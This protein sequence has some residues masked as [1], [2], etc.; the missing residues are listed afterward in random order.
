MEEILNA[1]RFEIEMLLFGI[2][3]NPHTHIGTHHLS[4]K[5]NLAQSIAHQMKKKPM[6][7]KKV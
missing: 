4:K 2:H 6:L 7:G 3:T 5:A 1:A